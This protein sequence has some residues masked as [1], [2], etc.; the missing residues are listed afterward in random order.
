MRAA[1]KAVTA[2]RDPQTDLIVRGL[3]S[4]KDLASFLN[5]LEAESEQKFELSPS[6]A[7][8][9]ERARSSRRSQS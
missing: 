2:A 6:P 9:P 8:R 7:I 1:A 3:A 4:P 5:S